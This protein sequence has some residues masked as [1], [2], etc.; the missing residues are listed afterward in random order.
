MTDDPERQ[1]KDDAAEVKRIEAL[2]L[3]A[4]R[5]YEPAAENSIAVLAGLVNILLDITSQMNV[6]KDSFFDSLAETWDTTRAMTKE[7]EATQVTTTI[8]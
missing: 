2:L 4:L 5:E 6:D 8:H 7:A 3:D 1:A